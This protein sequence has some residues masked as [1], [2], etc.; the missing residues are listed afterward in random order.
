MM[1]SHV[2]L[3]DDNPVDN[4]LHEQMLRN[5]DEEIEISIIDNSRLALKFLEQEFSK[6]SL[7]MKTT[8]FLDE[9]MPQI[10]GVEIMESLEKM[11]LIKNEQVQVYFLTTDTSSSLRKKAEVMPSVKR[12]IH[13][14]LTAEL[15]E[16]ISL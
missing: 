9:I 4:V 16:E 10:C 8:I 2:I 13:K 6:D 5:F 7:E 14:P 1:K 11:E 12:V 15:I 3:I